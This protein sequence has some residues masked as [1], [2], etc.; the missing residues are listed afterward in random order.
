MCFNKSKK[1]NVKESNLM[2][3]VNETIFLIHHECC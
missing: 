1:I 2:A 3:G